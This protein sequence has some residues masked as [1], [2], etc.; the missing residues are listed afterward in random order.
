MEKIIENGTEVFIFNY[1]RGTYGEYPGVDNYI[2]G[3]IIS[4]KSSG[5]LSYHGS[6]WE[7]QIYEVLGEDNEKYYGPYGSGLMYSH[8]FRTR[9]DHIDWIE[10]LIERN[11]SKIK[12]ISAENDSYRAKIDSLIAEGRDKPYVYQKVNKNEH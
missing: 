11:N 4:S 6:P 2:K 7:I 1:A 8:F 9:E 12:E 5:D 3:T 10:R